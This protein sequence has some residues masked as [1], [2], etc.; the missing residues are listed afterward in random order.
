MGVISH[1]QAIDH[2]AQG[3]SL[4]E[5]IGGAAVVPQGQFGR[6]DRPVAVQG[7]PERVQ[8]ESP[9]IAGQFSSQRLRLP[10]NSLMENGMNSRLQALLRDYRR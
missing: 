5:Q 9:V 10:T 6:D 4:I 8:S 7:L 1:L 3:L 2:V